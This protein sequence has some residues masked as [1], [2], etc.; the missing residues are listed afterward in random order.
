MLTLV[1]QL[2]FSQGLPAPTPAPDPSRPWEQPAQ[3]PPEPVVPPMAPKDAVTPVPEPDELNPEAPPPGYLQKR[4]EGP[5]R[6]ARS[7][8]STGGGV[9]GG[10]A[11]L[12]IAETIGLSNQRLD[13]N[14][15][16]AALASIMIAGV[17]FTVQ[18]AMGGHGEVTFALFGAIA[19]M[20]CAA[21]VAQGID[22]TGQNVAWLTTAI[23]SV[24]AAAAS[25]ALLELS[26]PEKMSISMSAGPGS[27]LVRF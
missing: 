4:P 25:V 16:N 26:T 5:S 15:A 10:A 14:F 3:P 13:I 23:G 11:A 9:I 18:H 27:L 22:S 24:P 7:A 2:A 12:A 17:S 6:F 1:L 8:A 21:L 20:A 19:M